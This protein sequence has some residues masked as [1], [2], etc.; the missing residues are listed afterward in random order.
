MDW[1][2][3]RSSIA[4]FA[5]SDA[6]EGPVLRWSVAGIV[7]LLVWV[8]LVEPVQIWRNT[9]EERVARDARKAVRLQSLQAHADDWK[10]SLDES[11]QLLE[12]S[13]GSLFTQDSDTAAQAQLQQWLVRQLN[14]R[15][16]KVGNQRLIE[17]EKAPGVGTRVSV[18]LDFRGELLDVLK[19]LDDVSRATYLIEIEQW[20]MRQGRYGEIQVQATLAAYR[21]DEEELRTNGN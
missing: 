7:L 1:S 8:W 11:E 6:A 5:S 10:T 14:A 12:K 17:P 15:D 19:F 3:V 13:F 18:F 16:L 2:Q 21:A 9:L 4:T 20:L